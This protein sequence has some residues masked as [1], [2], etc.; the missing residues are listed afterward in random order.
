MNSRF[1]ALPPSAFT[2]SDVVALYLHRGAFENALADLRPGT[3]PRPMGQ[4]YGKRSRGMANRLSVALEPPVGV[5][6]C[7]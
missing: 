2:A 7:A 4:P 1:P 3:R 5:G 6:S